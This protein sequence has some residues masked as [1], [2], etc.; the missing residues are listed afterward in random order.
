M[1]DE[2]RIQKLCGVIQDNITRMENC[3]DDFVLSEIEKNLEESV[4]YTSKDYKKMLFNA[5]NSFKKNTRFMANEI[6]KREN[7]IRSLYKS[8]KDFNEQQQKVDMSVF[9]ILPSDDNDE[10][11]D[12][13]DDVNII[14]ACEKI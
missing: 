4:N 7:L 13:L 1:R 10:I 11:P 8:M 2:I 14:E 5:L 3:P 9:G 12:V 6:I